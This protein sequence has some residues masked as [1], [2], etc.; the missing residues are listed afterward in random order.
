MAILNVE[1]TLPDREWVAAVEKAIS[2]LQ[3]ENLQLKQDIAEARN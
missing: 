3:A 1:S 2:D